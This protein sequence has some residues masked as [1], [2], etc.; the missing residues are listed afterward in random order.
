M[1]SKI[2]ENEYYLEIFMNHSRF[3]KLLIHLGG[4]LKTRKEIIKFILTNGQ[5]DSIIAENLG[6]SESRE[7]FNNTTC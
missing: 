1:K 6:S 7:L 3:S 5:N 4:D 2:R